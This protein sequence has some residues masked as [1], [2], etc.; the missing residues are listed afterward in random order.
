MDNNTIKKELEQ[1]FVLLKDR[2]FGKIVQL[3]NEWNQDAQKIQ[4][5]YQEVEKAL[6]PAEKPIETK[7]ETKK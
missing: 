3:V 5:K 1:D 2:T 6:A 7:V 4:A